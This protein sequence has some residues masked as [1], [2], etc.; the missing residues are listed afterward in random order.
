MTNKFDKSLARQM[1][2]KGRR[3]KSPESGMKKVTS[4]RIQYILKEQIEYYKQ[5]DANKFDNLNEIDNS[6]KKKYIT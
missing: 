2:E 1:K 5:L 6:L 3:H 4:L